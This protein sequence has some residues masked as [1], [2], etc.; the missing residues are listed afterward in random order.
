M[1]R[2]IIAIWCLLICLCSLPIEGQVS[3]LS[4][5][6][7]GTGIGALSNPKKT[8]NTNV[9]VGKVTLGNIQGGGFVL[10]IDSLK[11]GKFVRHVGS[12]TDDAFAGNIVNYTV[13][14][15]AAG[16][17]SLGTNEPLL[18]N[19]HELATPIS[20]TFTAKLPTENTVNYVYTLALTTSP[21]NLQFEGTFRDDLTFTL[22][23][24]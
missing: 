8:A 24:I 21:N 12:Y 1:S 9:V 18:P 23:D 10:A 14:L 13:S 16:S 19:N 7:S 20:L 5:Q 2:G 3:T 11:N 4:V 15:M 6:T 17:G 22:T